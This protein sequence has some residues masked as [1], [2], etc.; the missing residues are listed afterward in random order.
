MFECSSK[1]MNAL[2]LLC[3]YLV[4]LKENGINLV[5]MQIKLNIKFNKYSLPN[6]H[7]RIL[8]C[9][10]PFYFIW[11]KKTHAFDL[12]SISTADR[13]IKIMIKVSI[14]IIFFPDSLPNVSLSPS[15]TNTKNTLLFLN[16]NLHYVRL[17]CLY[18]CLYLL[19]SPTVWQGY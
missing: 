1:I 10:M 11:R 9:A 5:S 2:L 3:K 4:P 14:V 12:K 6:K 15:S 17:Y 13:K 7:W 19:Q 16:S 8:L 18:I